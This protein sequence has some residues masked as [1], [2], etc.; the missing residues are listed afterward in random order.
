MVAARGVALA[1]LAA[2]FRVAD[3]FGEVELSPA[4]FLSSKT[5]YYPQQ[6]YS[7][8]ESVPAH[9]RLVHVN[10]LGRHGSRHST[11]LKSSLHLYDALTEALRLGHLKPRGVVLLQSVARFVEGERDRLGRCGLRLSRV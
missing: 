7:T 9:C 4:L 1:F 2:F 10:H 8:Y 11:K 3:T 6:H 5:P